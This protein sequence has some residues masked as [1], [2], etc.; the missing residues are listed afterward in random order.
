M[1][2][3][4]AAELQSSLDFRES[5]NSGGDIPVVAHNPPVATFKGLGFGH[6]GRW[7]PVQNLRKLLWACIVLKALAQ[8]PFDFPP[9]SFALIKLQLKASKSSKHVTF[10]TAPG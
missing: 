7:H 10:M 1:A 5:A 4:F 6:Q 8:P 3:A 2:A 9:S